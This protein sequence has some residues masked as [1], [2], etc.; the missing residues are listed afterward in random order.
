MD[1]FKGC[2]QFIAGRLL[3]EIT[4]RTDGQGIED[5]VGVLVNGKHYKLGVRQLRLQ[6]T[7]TFNPAHARQ[8]DVHQH[9]ARLFR[10]QLHQR[11]LGASILAHAAE[12]VRMPDPVRK[13][14]PR[15]PII[16]N[17]RNRNTHYLSFYIRFHKEGCR[18]F[19]RR[20]CRAAPDDRF[21]PCVLAGIINFI[22]I[23]CPVAMDF[24]T[25]GTPGRRVRKRIPKCCSAR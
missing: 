17:D 13:D 4:A 12:S 6:L 5:V 23:P 8:I 22:C 18:L 1:V 9:H 7:H 21:K 10:L 24:A 3:Q 15:R 25:A 2:E 11:A 20:C 16:F 14:L 19:R